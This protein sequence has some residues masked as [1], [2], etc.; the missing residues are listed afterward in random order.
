MNWHDSGRFCTDS[1]ESAAKR[2]K[3]LG[4]SI[5]PLQGGRNPQQPKLPAIRWARYQY[6]IATDEELHDWFGAEPQAGIGIV[7][8]RVSRLMVLDFDDASEASEFRHLFPD[9]VHTLVV[10]SGTRG[11][12]H[13][14]YRLPAGKVVPTTAY[15]GV[16]LRGEG[17]YVVAPPTRI[18]DAAW[19]VECDVPIHEITDLELRRIVGF[20]TSRKPA[21]ETSPCES[22]SVSTQPEA[23]EFRHIMTREELV[24]YYRERCCRGRNQALFQT[25][26]MARDMGITETAFVVMLAGVHAAEPGTRHE[27]YSGR[28]A[29]AIRTIASAYS[30]PVRQ[31]KAVYAGLSNSV[32]EWLLSHGLANVARVIDGLF[33]VGMKPGEMFTEAEA[34][35]HLAR[36]KIGR[37]SIM[38]ALKCAVDDFEVFGS[39]DTP[40]V[41]PV[42]A[43]A[44]KVAQSLTHSCEMSSGAKRVN[45]GGRG[46]PA[47]LYRLPST[48][49]VA[50]QIGVSGQGGD[51]VTE[52]DFE[53]VKAYRAALHEKLIERRPGHY[54]R[55]WLAARLGVS[56]WTARR[57][58]KALG[59]LVQ[60][61]FTDDK[62]TWSSARRLPE[63]KLGLTRGVFI[64]TGDG[65]RYPAVRGLALKLLKTSQNAVLRQ[66]HG[67]FYAVRPISV[68][69]PTPQAISL[70]Q[71]AKMQGYE[72]GVELKH[73]QQ[74]S[75]GIPTVQVVHGRQ[76]EGINET[77]MPA[78][79]LEANGRPNRLSV[80]IP[81][82]Q[83]TEPLFWLCP[84]CLNF[85]V[86]ERQPERC[87]RCGHTAEWE[88]LSPTIW[89]NPEAL[90]V[91]WQDRYRDHQATKRQQA[92]TTVPNDQPHIAENDQLLADRLHT[93][94]PQLSLRNARQLV[95]RFSH[96]LIEKALNVI[97]AR[98]GLRNPAGFLI[99]FLK[100]ESKSVVGQQK[101]IVTKPKGESAMD[102][103]R[104]LATSEYL[105]FISNAD[106]ILNIDQKSDFITAWG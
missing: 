14:Y 106:D 73:E 52:R 58:E 45:N 57:Y 104:R 69:I 83:K 17:S 22:L 33:V 2:Y 78:K 27:P 24:Q 105:N 28:Y 15:H 47:R 53:S 8:G 4:F 20:L 49:E 63:T 71:Q 43:Y 98:G 50:K 36:L 12:P 91:W 44:A 82:P 100:S 65:K 77:D 26:V 102:W 101:G 6:T 11:L 97:H 42:E 95:D 37:R 32:R 29:E 19:V 54:A 30:R 93:Q 16:D 55:A 87:M 103:L 90:K 64:E 5:I 66:Q 38:A 7:C 76:A 9:L 68:G 31:D 10:R 23:S 62:L 89:R 1:A 41:P 51:A 80:G 99:S 13:F 25:S 59:L 21:S 70:R 56:R 67:N 84:E 92:T 74:L 60:P 48:D 72:S 35:K 86:M 3:T 94:V 81:T 85:H 39:S 18:G 46:R 75:V 88:I 61:A 96:H 34:C 79:I 40:H